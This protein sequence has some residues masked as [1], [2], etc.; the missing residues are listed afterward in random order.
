MSITDT[1]TLN[2]KFPII[3]STEAI[4]SALHTALWSKFLSV[5]RVALAYFVD[6]ALTCHWPAG[7]VGKNSALSVTL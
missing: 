2:E 5:A 4:S 1:S 3:K 6:V 7:V